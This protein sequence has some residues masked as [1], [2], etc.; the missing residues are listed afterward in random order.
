VKALQVCSGEVPHIVRMGTIRRLIH[1][2]L[3]HRNK[4]RAVSAR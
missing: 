2:Y 4:R 1:H 3:E